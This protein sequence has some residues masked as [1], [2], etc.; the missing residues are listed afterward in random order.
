MPE[1][2]KLSTKTANF[3]EVYVIE[4]LQQPIKPHTVT[5]GTGDA[6]RDKPIDLIIAL[7]AAVAANPDYPQLSAEDRQAFMEHF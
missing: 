5:L 2:K 1:R 7:D 6:T 3:T 4:L